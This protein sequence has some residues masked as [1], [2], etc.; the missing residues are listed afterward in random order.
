MQLQGE[1]LPVCDSDLISLADL[2]REL[3]VS[4]ATG[5][6]WLR[7][8]KIVPQSMIRNSAFFS[9]EYLLQLQGNLRSEKNEL[10]KRRRNK[11]YISGNN[12]YD[13]YV[14]ATSENVHSVERIVSYIEEKN[15]ELT[16]D[17][18]CAIVAECAIQLILEKEGCDKCTKALLKYINKEIPTSTYWFL[19]DDL[20]MNHPDIKTMI[21]Q[22]PALFH[23][24]FV[25]KSSEDT[26][27]LLYISLNNMGNRK[28]TGSYY[29][30]TEV[31]QKLCDKLFEMN[32]PVGKRVFDPCC[33]TGNFILQLP[34]EIAFE[35]VYGNDADL[36]SVY[37]ARLNYALKYSVCDAQIVYSHITQRDYL[38]SD[39][40]AKFDFIIGN[41]PWGCDFSDEQ[42]ERLRQK[43]SCASGNSIESYD[44]FVEQALSNLMPGGILSFVLPEAILNVRNH[45]QIRKILLAHSRFQYIEFLGNVFDKVQCPCIILQTIRSDNGFSTVGLK[46]AD[47]AREFIINTQREIDEKCIVF[48]MTD[49]EYRVMRKIN[50]EPNRTTLFGNARFALGIVTGNNKK[51]ISQNKTDENEMILRGA[52]LYKFRYT[53]SSNYIVFKPD[54]FQ[55]IAPIECYR[56]SEKLL[57]RFICNQ[58]VFAYDDAQ[59]LSLNSCN[60]LIPQIPELSI[61]YIMAILNSRIAQF[62]FKKRFHSVKVLRSHIEQI[63]IP[64][65]EKI[66]Q[67]EIVEA[68]E[69]IL[70]STQDQRIYELY[71]TL[72]EKISRLYGLDEEDYAIIRASMEGE[73]L[74]L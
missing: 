41:P 52:D 73:N 1:K 2:C 50:D 43:Y 39:E 29:T 13:S 53:S 21:E 23:Y 37:L 28:A 57:Y 11:K 66:F 19:V 58:L 7:L 26:L 36:M 4:I 12:V 48:S 38:L 46:I 54:Y 61:K 24:P 14:C 10:L 35:N 5:R 74:F 51:Y 3:S 59:R 60:I 32:H 55:Q 20:L 70:Q 63:P 42:R 67:D 71:N 15:I 30:P 27:G 62:Y 40:F 33:G 8:G 6:N 16:S 65:I 47:A 69:S 44:V 64:K 72:D 56:A 18:L 34:L 49:E 25:Y 22:Y 17:L 45:T 9:R 68:V 31:A